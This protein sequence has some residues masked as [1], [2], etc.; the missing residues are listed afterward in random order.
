MEIPKVVDPI[1]RPDWSIMGKLSM[2][3]LLSLATAPAGMPGN[4]WEQ[5]ILLKTL[6]IPVLLWRIRV[7][8]KLVCIILTSAVHLELSIS[9]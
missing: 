9:T 2:I 7:L 4:Y 6:L 1:I 3:L 8:I 5:I